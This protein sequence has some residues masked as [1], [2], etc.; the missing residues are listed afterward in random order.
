VWGEG[1]IKEKENEIRCMGREEGCENYG[2]REE[3]ER[4]I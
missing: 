4:S 1:W 2:S 3:K